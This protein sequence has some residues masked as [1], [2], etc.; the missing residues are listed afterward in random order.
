MKTCVLALA[1][2]F[3]AGFTEG[4]EPR[5][6]LPPGWS[7]L[8]LT[9]AQATEVRRIRADTKHKADALE[10]QLRDLRAAERKQLLAVLSDA[11]KARLKEIAQEKAGEVPAKDK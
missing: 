2:A 7:K 1:A 6:T 3:A 4:Q 8:G 5:G 11:Q 10:Q 9:D